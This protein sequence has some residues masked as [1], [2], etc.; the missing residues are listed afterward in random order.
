MMGAQTKDMKRK[1]EFE[2]QTFNEFL[3]WDLDDLGDPK[4]YAFS[5]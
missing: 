4:T 2:V 3:A 5:W 1:L